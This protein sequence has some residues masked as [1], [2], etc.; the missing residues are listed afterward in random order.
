MLN[1]MRVLDLTRLLPGP[2]CTML[3]ADLGAEVIKVE[4]PY[5]GDYLR[6]YPPQLDGMSATFR[7]LNRNKKSIAL[8]LKRPRG[9]EIFVRLAAGADIVIEGF[10]PGAAARLGIDY[11]S[12]CRVNPRLIY[13]SLSGFGQSGPY[14]DIAAHDINYVA[15]AGM[16]SLF[17]AHDGAPALPG[18]QLAD[19]SG[20]L[21]AAIAVLAAAV[22]RQRSGRG[23]F[24]DVSL[25]DSAAAWLLYLAGFFLASGEAPAP[26]ATPLTGL[27][28]CY[29]L[30]RAKDGRFISVGALEPKFWSNLC[31]FLGR[32]DL[33]GSQ[34]ATG[35]RGDEAKR[36][37]ADI[38]ATKSSE[39]WWRDL[40]SQEVCCA[41]VRD[42]RQVFE[43]PQLRQRG[44]VARVEDWD[45]LPPLFSPFSQ[46]VGRA[47]RH[48]EHTLE[49]L[50]EL[51]YSDAEIDELEGAGVIKKLSPTLGDSER[52][53]P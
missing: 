5:S 49:L 14:R 51:D 8:D 37:L 44:I 41:P 33:I 52:P 28:P 30:Y 15:L 10:R 13:C 4:D 31:R 19:V 6:N 25:F 43:D 46:R 24:L 2:F 26:G 53:E 18:I 7:L 20:G 45:Q 1:G 48:G 34:Y 50:R 29:N 22:S 23:A 17:P 36:A 16:A 32:E 9:L 12:L 11:E 3:L 47:P 35:A 27:F 42:I 38:F 39:E 40:K 21:F